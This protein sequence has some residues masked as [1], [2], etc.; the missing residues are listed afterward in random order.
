[1]R[2]ADNMN[3]VREE[4]SDYPMGC[5]TRGNSCEDVVFF[6]TDQEQ[7]IRY[8]R[9][10]N[11]LYQ[12]AVSDEKCRGTNVEW[13]Q[14]GGGYRDVAFV[15]S[16]SESYREASNCNTQY[17]VIIKGNDIS[18][19]PYDLES[20]SKLL[21]HPSGLPIVY[22]GA[23]GKDA[24]FEIYMP[25]NLS[26]PAA[27]VSF[28]GIG[29]EFEPWVSLSR[30]GRT[31]AVSHPWQRRI[32]I[33]DLFTGTLIGDI[34]E[35]TEAK[36]SPDGERLL[37]VKT[38]R[39]RV[40]SVFS[41]YGEHQCSLGTVEYQKSIQFGYLDNSHHEVRQTSLWCDSGRKVFLLDGNKVSE[42]RLRD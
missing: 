14:I 25:S 21:P 1:M 2:D 42:Y 35:H 19:T 37:A 31:A 32:F 7:P 33:V 13:S 39:N 9:R 38:A 24:T 30:D 22:K 5:A 16:G 6:G 41:K 15:L 27:Q 29:G 34:P 11:G 28:P 4:I 36:F 40:A 10:Y 18:V 12:S 3:D 20:Y 8:F 23:Q 26:E 17:F